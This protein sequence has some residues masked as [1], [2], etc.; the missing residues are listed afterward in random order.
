MPSE[1]LTKTKYPNIYKTVSNKYY[2]RKMINKKLIVRL[3]G[4]DLTDKQAQLKS[5]TI[6]NNLTSKPKHFKSFLEYKTEYINM[7]KN[8][9][10][11]YWEQRTNTE[12]SK[13]DMFNKR[14]LLSIT[15]E[16]YQRVINVLLDTYST[17]YVKNSKDSLSAMYNY[18]KLDNKAKHLKIPKFDNKVYF[19]LKEEEVSQL[20]E[21]INTYPNIKYRCFFLLGLT[22]RRKGEIS[23]LK[24]KNIDMNNCVIHIDYFN[25]K[26]R[27]NMTYPISTNIRDNLNDLYMSSC[28]EQDDYVFTT[29]SNTPLYWVNKK[30]NRLCKD[31]N[32]K[33]RL[34]DLRHLVGY[35]AINKGYSLEQIGATLGHSSIE[36]TRRYSKLKEDT[37]RELLSDLY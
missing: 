14:D 11:K 30:W 21:A 35:L 29:S 9:Y 10:S 36:T 24:W 13:F 37:A 26:N 12:L 18:F 1:N 15:E 2:L 20:V 7:N 6:L 25:S 28:L 19:S 3:I 16:E 22:G 33:M 23:T 31:I 5:I 17:S 34:H 32:V 27:R 4:Q 8:L